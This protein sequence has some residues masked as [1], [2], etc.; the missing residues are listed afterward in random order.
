MVRTGTLRTISSAHLDRGNGGW[1]VFWPDVAIAR[2][3]RCLHGCPSC[4][5]FEKAVPLIASPL[6]T[7][8]AS[9]PTS[10][11]A[12]ATQQAEQRQLDPVRSVV[13]PINAY[14]CLYTLQSSS[15]ASA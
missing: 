15:D 11:G 14:G 12:S 9:A 10:C 3:M 8:G 13:A 6:S 7:C 1:R 4:T 2:Q 5:I